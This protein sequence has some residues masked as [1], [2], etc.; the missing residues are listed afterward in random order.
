MADC[1]NE[2]SCAGIY[3]ADVFAYIMHIYRV[4]VVIRYT[5]AYVNV[6][7]HT[8]ALMYPCLR[9]AFVVV[10]SDTLNAHL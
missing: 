10:H 9:M 1:D 4:V 6:H 8:I 5:N 7:S 2:L 3:I